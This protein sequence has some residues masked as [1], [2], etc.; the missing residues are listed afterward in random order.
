M[1]EIKEVD[2]LHDR[3]Q[4]P[5][6]AKLFSEIIALNHPNEPNYELNHDDINLMVLFEILEE[7]REI[8][9]L[10]NERNDK[11]WECGECFWCPCPTEVMDKY[12]GKKGE[13]PYFAEDEE[14]AMESLKGAHW[15][16]EVE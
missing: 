11:P 13:C 6:K 12:V 10:L 2:V 4:R 9:L 15:E 8:K 1:D 7:L 5:D 3:G 16:L 14:G